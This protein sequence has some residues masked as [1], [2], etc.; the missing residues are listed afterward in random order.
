MR[1]VVQTVGHRIEDLVDNSGGSFRQS[2]RCGPKRHEHHDDRHNATN[3]FNYI[4]DILLL[5]T[6]NDKTS[7]NQ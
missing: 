7:K 3:T 4:N 6:A 5:R 2:T 1:K